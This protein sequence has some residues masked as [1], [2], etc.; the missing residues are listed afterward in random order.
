[1]SDNAKRERNMVTI[2]FENISSD[3]I[4]QLIILTNEIHSSIRDLN[5]H[6]SKLSSIEQEP[7][8]LP[9]LWCTL[10]KTTDLLC[11]E[12]IYSRILILIFYFA[13]KS[14]LFIYDILS[15]YSVSRIKNTFKKNSSNNFMD[16]SNNNHLII[17]LNEFNYLQYILNQINP[18][19]FYHSI[20]Q[21]SNEFLI[22][23][24]TIYLLN[25]YNSDQYSINLFNLLNSFIDCFNQLIN[26]PLNIIKTIESNVKLNDPIHDNDNDDVI[27]S[28][29]KLK[30]LI[31]MDS[32]ICVKT[33]ITMNSLK[34]VQIFKYLIIVIE[35]LV[36]IPV[37]TMKELENRYN[38]N[39]IYSICYRLHLL[40]E[41][42]NTTTEDNQPLQYEECKSRIQHQQQITDLITQG[43]DLNHKLMIWSANCHSLL[44]RWKRLSTQVDWFN[45]HIQN[46]WNRLPET[47]MPNPPQFKLDY[48][49][50]ETNKKN[51]F[52]NDIK[53]IS[54][55]QV[56]YNILISANSLDAL[57]YY[58]SWIENIFKSFKSLIPICE[59]ILCEGQSLTNELLHINTMN[60][61]EN[62]VDLIESTQKTSSSLEFFNHN[63]NNNNTFWNKEFK[64]FLDL[65]IEWLFNLLV[66]FN[67]QIFYIQ[68]LENCINDLTL[69][70]ISKNNQLDYIM[71]QY[72]I[73]MKQYSNDLYRNIKGFN[74]IDDIISDLYINEKMI[75]LNNLKLYI[76]QLN[77]N[78]LHCQNYLFYSR[79]MN[80]S[81]W[82][83]KVYNDCLL[84][85][86]QILN[87][88][89]QIILR[90][91]LQL[92][93]NHE[94][95]SIIFNVLYSHFHDWF[96]LIMKRFSDHDLKF[97]QLNGISNQIL[98]DLTQNL[99]RQLEIRLPILLEL[100]NLEQQLWINYKNCDNDDDDNN[101]VTVSYSEQIVQCKKYMETLKQVQINLLTDLNKYEQLNLCFNQ[102]FIEIEVFNIKY[103]DIT[104]YTDV[105]KNFF[106]KYSKTTDLKWGNKNQTNENLRKHF[107]SR[108]ISLRNKT[109][110]FI[111]N[112]K[113]TQMN[114]LKIIIDFHKIPINQINQYLL[115]N[116]TLNT[117]LEKLNYINVQLYNNFIE[118]NDS[119]EN[120]QL[121]L[122]NNNNNNNNN[123]KNNNNNNNNNNNDCLKSVVIENLIKFY[124]FLHQ[125]IHLYGR[126]NFLQQIN[127]QFNLIKNFHDSKSF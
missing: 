73:Q 52:I 13:Y 79:L 83:I 88:Y 110:Q 4:D 34:T 107:N 53:F 106:S 108:L 77:K 17:L 101:N 15:V 104:I 118:Y 32:F 75:Q 121:L 81:Q 112:S 78:E 69:W 80:S 67:Q 65:I 82:I 28:N 89:Q 46:L 57:L 22:Q 93:I 33:S 86:K 92:S 40:N 95:Y 97:I 45:V 72:K 120:D 6:L 37:L 85:Y 102:L 99:Y 76:D 43:L 98:Y 56:S 24:T 50:L 20:N 64:I 113:L 74:E 3:L 116:E 111:S 61:H 7:F 47:P 114:T 23:F 96:N 41:S 68:L 126:V 125:L 11:I 10:F 62:I 54:P 16:A 48:L 58:K 18:S 100:Y 9:N 59:A 2:Y 66:E 8:P 5:K 25:K 87:H 84:Q 124:Q 127:E 71:K 12:M 29:N 122:S 90:N 14:L 117:L 94:N 31:I 30:N 109:E 105:D 91:I 123:N 115:K 1:M 19:N 42:S 63:D 39:L 27:M 119:I 21:Q 60:S 51:Q 35:S 44:D 70:I 49:L 38:K 55:I 103:P 36:N 26:F